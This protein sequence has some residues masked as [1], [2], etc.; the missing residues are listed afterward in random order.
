MDLG[1]ALS[2]RTSHGVRKEGRIPAGQQRIEWKLLTSTAPPRVA[3][4]QR[5]SSPRAFGPALPA[6][7]ARSRYRCPQFPGRHVRHHAARIE[8]DPRTSRLEHRSPR[9]RVGMRPPH[10]AP[11]TRPRAM[12]RLKHLSCRPAPAPRRARRATRRAPPYIRHPQ[13][14]NPSLHLASFKP[15]FPLPFQCAP[16]YADGWRGKGENQ[17]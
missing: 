3:S 14:P 5:R 17:R 16:V 15:K 2:R 1:V 11:A 10:L 8:P 13:G 6:R 7:H 9:C 4:S 12:R